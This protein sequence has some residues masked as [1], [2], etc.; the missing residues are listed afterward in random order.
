MDKYTYT[1]KQG[2][3]SSGEQTCYSREES[4]TDDHISVEGYLLERELST[5]FRR[6][7]IRM[8]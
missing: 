1:L 3:V 5:G 4:G 6:R 8:C 2:G 7:W